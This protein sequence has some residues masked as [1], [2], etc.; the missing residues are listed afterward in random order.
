MA[1]DG[2]DR[3]FPTAPMALAALIPRLT[4]PAF[5]KRSPAGAQIMAD[6]AVIIGPAIAA[7]TQPIRL[8]GGTLTLG[9][10]GPIAMELQHLA[11]ELIS[12]INAHLGR[13]AVERL[14]FVQHFQG[15]DQR[16]APPARPIPLPAELEARLAGLPAGELRDALAKLAH[17]VYRKR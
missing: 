9:C 12:R 8:T 7:S 1:D 14:K 16:V 11:P 13:A 2:N 4:R 17:G 6:W 10:A 5:R 15:R 3:R